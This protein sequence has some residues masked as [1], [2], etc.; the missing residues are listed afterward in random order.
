MFEEKKLTPDE[1]VQDFNKR[2]KVGDTVLWRDFANSYY[3]YV[4]RIVRIPAIIRGDLPV[5]FFEDSFCSEIIDTGL[6]KDPLPVC[7]KCGLEISGTK[8]DS[9]HCGL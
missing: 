9:D 7:D 2:Y 3:K 5:V 8:C 1:L 6:I 4:K